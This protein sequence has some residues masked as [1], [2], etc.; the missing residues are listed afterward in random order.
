M[1]NDHSNPDPAEQNN[2]LDEALAQFQIG[3]RRPTNF[4][5]HGL[6]A[7]LLDVR[8]SLDQHAGLVDHPLGG[9]RAGRLIRL[10]HRPRSIG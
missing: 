7:K 3:K 4:D 9:M 6:A 5:D 10:A 2:V 8:K 1:N